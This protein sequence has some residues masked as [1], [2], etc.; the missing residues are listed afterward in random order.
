MYTMYIMYILPSYD[1]CST[2]FFHFTIQTDSQRLVKSFSKKI[3]KFL[4]I[5]LFV[6]VKNK[7]CNYMM[8]IDKQV[9]LLNDINIMPFKLRFLRNFIKFL[10]SNLTN[11]STT[12]LMSYILSFKK[13][14]PF[15]VY[16]FKNSFKDSG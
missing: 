8:D 1:Y 15:R 16:S 13:D 9:K 4:K 14:M 7:S 6:N 2:L 10:N 5:Q 3:F 11:F 12:F